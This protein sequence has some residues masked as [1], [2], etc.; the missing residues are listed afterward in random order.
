MSVKPIIPS[1]S[2]NNNKV[3]IKNNSSSSN[4]LQ[5]KNVSFRGGSP[6]IIVGMMDAIE[7]GGYPASFIIQD[8]LGFITPRVGK[9]LVRD[10]HDKKDEN[11]NVVLGKDGK[12]VRQLN[13][14]LARKE[15][16]REIITGPSAFVIPLAMLHVIKKHFGRGNNVKLN[17]I[18]GFQK[19]FTEFAQN[20]TDAIKNGTANKAIFYKKIFSNAIET[21]INSVLPDSAKMTADEI[22]KTANNLTA[23]QIQIEKI[24]ADKTLDKK[25]KKEALSK[26]GSVV[27]DFMKLKKGK[28][29]GAVDEMAV[30]FAASN[31]KVKTGSIGEMV[32]AMS[33]YFDDAV[34]NT[35]EEL[36]KGLKSENIES[37]V[38]KLTNRK[39]GS[40]ILTNLGIFGAV[41]AFY[42]QIPKL[43]NMGLKGNPALQGTAVDTSN[44]AANGNTPE[45]KKVKGDNP[46]F[47]KKNVAFTGMGS[48][49]EKAGDKIFNN[50]S[51]KTVSDIFELNG[52]IMS[53]NAMTTLLF[54]FCIPPRLANAQDKYD[55]GEI[56]VR[57]MTAFTALLFGA[58]ALSRVFSDVFSNI[59]GLALN[60][61]NMDGHNTL[62]KVIDYLNPNDTHHSVL[63]RKQLT[64]KYTH[65]E[66]YK[67]GVNGFMDFIE[68]S[69][70]D[71]KKAFSC[72]KKI[73]A[74]VDEILKSFNGKSFKDATSKE[75]K[76]VLKKANAQKSDSI[77]K[78]YNLF[79]ENNGL[80]NKARTC[81][82]SFG[83][84][85]TI[86]LV[87]GLIIWLTDFCE[88]MTEKRSK[89]DLAAAEKTGNTTQ[90]N[91]AETYLAEHNQPTK[92]PSM[93]GFLG[94]K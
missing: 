2:S 63:S 90:I 92:T 55:Y 1:I 51:A 21:S 94:R 46:S 19:P 5:K 32:N 54:G 47:G 53:A 15:F 37:F 69:G 62:H 24:K 70:G 64:S 84:L 31:G 79:H 14:A 26:I 57:D 38:K 88:K 56:V 73:Q 74:S 82:S 41:A 86:V 22:S 6:N 78:F 18:D 91:A 8:G 66:D 45:D 50:K 20:N 17:Y 43:Y 83:F 7:A 71:V 9:G 81:N 16:L 35:H 23:K 87:P 3:Q 58:K 40:R 89:K 30:Q 68:S 80:L 48:F 77:K 34:K 61:K 11:G 10:A 75:I 39:M 93:A 42:T 33:D 65:L 44:P 25:A 29:G 13:W 60:K 76:E 27:D 12:P 49:L 4:N 59:T 85:S 52:P 28:I 36:K 72:D 67:G